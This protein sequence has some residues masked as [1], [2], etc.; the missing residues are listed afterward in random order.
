MKKEPLEDNS[1]C[2]AAC[3]NAKLIKKQTA[4]NN[5]FRETGGHSY[6][7]GKHLLQCVLGMERGSTR[8]WLQ[9]H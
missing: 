7:H 6:K 8:K 3:Q 1:G 2:Q 5:L 4:G 9:F